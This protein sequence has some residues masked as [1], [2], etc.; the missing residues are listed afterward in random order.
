[1]AE[2]ARNGQK[3]EV[4]RGLD[5]SSG[6]EDDNDNDND[7]DNVQS[8]STTAVMQCSADSKH[9]MPSSIQSHAPGAADAPALVRVDSDLFDASDAKHT[10]ATSSNNLARQQ[11]QQQRDSKSTATATDDQDSEDDIED[12]FG[13][14]MPS[15]ADLL[16]P[17]DTPNIPEIAAAQTMLTRSAEKQRQRKA[18]SGGSGSKQRTKST[19]PRLFPLF[20]T[21]VLTDM[22]V[23]ASAANKSEVSVSAVA[24]PQ[25]LHK[26][27][28][29]NPATDAAD[30]APDNDARLRTSADASSSSS[31]VPATSSADS[32]PMRPA[33]TKS[34][35]EQ[36]TLERV[37][38]RLSSHP[39][40]L[41]LAVS[42]FAAGLPIIQRILS[43][44]H[45]D[46][47]TGRDSHNRTA[48]I[49]ASACGHFPIVK[50]LVEER[51][52]NVNHRAAF[53]YTPLFGACEH[54]HSYIV[55][56]L[57]EHKASPELPS[58]KKSVVT[59]L[60]LAA[61]G[62]HVDVVRILLEHGVDP[63]VPDRQGW[64]ALMLSAR[65][66]FFEL[67]CLL[68]KHG[69]D[70]VHSKRNGK[71]ALMKA[72]RNGHTDIVRALL[73]D[74]R[75]PID[76]TDRGGWS[77]LMHASQQGST[78]TAR[79][80]LERGAD[81]D[82]RE[83]DGWTALISAAV[84]GHVE[85]VSLLL[86]FNA[87]A[88]LAKSNGKTAL[89]KSA[90]AGS[91][92]IVRLLLK[93]G[94]RVNE[95]DSGGYTPLHWA[96][97]VGQESTTFAL[98]QHKA[99]INARTRKFATPIHLAACRGHDRIIKLLLDYDADIE[100]KTNVGKTPLAS[101]IC[102]G[103]ASSCEL[104]CKA[105]ADPNCTDSGGRSVFV[106][107]IYAKQLRMVK[108]LLNSRKPISKQLEQSGMYHAA[109][110]GDVRILRAILDR[111][112]DPNIKLPLS[113]RFAITTASA[114]GHI[115]CV[116]LLQQR[117]AH[118]HWNDSDMASRR[119]LPIW[120]AVDGQH[121]EVA[122]HLLHHGARLHV[123]SGMREHAPVRLARTKE[124]KHLVHVYLAF[125]HAFP[126]LAAASFPYRCMDLRETDM[127]T[128]TGSTAQPPVLRS[129]ILQGSLFDVNLVKLIVRFM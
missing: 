85:M 102:R 33:R 44:Q 73:D 127:I 53:M 52:A 9:N 10:T 112:V 18:A 82:T 121:T 109:K 17:D 76:A 128:G 75:T 30:H 5:E 64:T 24:V 69:A 88:D 54:G 129:F 86:E 124:M 118:I 89:M 58:R 15:A 81:A 27:T 32:T 87:T 104:L 113:R 83:R 26:S 74:P 28:I 63:S 99:D 108:A 62:N 94:A 20:P 16:L 11:Q 95:T 101:A 59:P 97:C 7:N 34:E 38:K 56:Y 49:I 42:S 90:R 120:F 123:E 105:G 111:G 122:R 70:P 48:L 40:R 103:Q 114:G 57:L 12:G 65:K 92:Q 50:F 78:E 43:D 98:L 14:S 23:N 60:M 31:S 77:A 46:P 6:S 115:D 71:T 41:L 29:Q 91:E 72:A 55:K 67:T 35:L 45:I 51:G 117:G 47:D 2:L 66:G 126:L 79:L 107:A 3:P 119:S 8:N 68:L 1:M 106:I 36:V 19:R 25:T 84:R 21:Q 116:K 125:E 100:L 37:E 96:A 93:H 61:R 80:L 22:K 110:V 13:W 39:E 4:I